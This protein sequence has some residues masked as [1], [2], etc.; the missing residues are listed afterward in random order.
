M[1]RIGL[2]FRDKR[3]FNPSNKGKTFPKDRK[4]ELKLQIKKRIEIELF[5]IQ[6]SPN[7]YERRSAV[8]R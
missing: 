1:P 4:G 6:F 3:N 8:R 7:K 2:R 5:R